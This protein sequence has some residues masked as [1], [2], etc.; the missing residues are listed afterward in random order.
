VLPSVDHLLQLDIDAQ[1][2]ISEIAEHLEDIDET[3]G[4]CNSARISWV[5][6]EMRQYRRVP[7]LVP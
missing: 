5:G 6:L 1:W 7:E 4:S 3:T 2:T